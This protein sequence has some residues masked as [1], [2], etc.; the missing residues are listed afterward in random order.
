MDDLS[1]ETR[2]R[3]VDLAWAAIRAQLGGQSLPREEGIRE[4]GQKRGAFVSL[5]RRSDREL[6]GCIGHVQPDLPVGEAVVRAAVGAATEDPRF[7][8][9]TL[10]ELPTLALEVSVLG[11]LVPISPEDVEVGT[12]GLLIRYQGQTGLLLPQ[13]PENYGWDR[14]T[15]LDFTCRKAGL[16][17][18]TWRKPGC[19]VLGFTATVFGDVG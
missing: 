2:R 12:H 9:V 16:P 19:E 8:S 1:P 3:L 17:A 15:F 6:R 10:E 14:E 13:V 4:L 7:R 5:K 11:P 18:G